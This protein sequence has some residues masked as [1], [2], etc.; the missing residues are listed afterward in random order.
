M[1]PSIEL[2]F[3]WL[4]TET[5]QRDPD[6]TSPHVLIMDGQ[7]SLWEEA[8]KRATTAPVEMLDLLHAT[9][10]IWKAAEQFHETKEG[11]E[12]FSRFY[13]TLLLQ[14]RVELVIASLKVFACDGK[15]NTQA[16]KEVEKVCGY[17]HNNR[18]RMQYDECLKAGY[19]IASGV[20]EG[21]CRYVVKDRM[22]RSGMRWQMRGACHAGFAV[23]HVK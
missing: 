12:V 7:K 20:I 23:Y 16:L 8:E 2:M 14:G 4:N 19:P 13:T 18:Q 3:S 1:Q 17:F 9:G 10:Y 6:A 22:E 21:A 15:I 5:D 11:K